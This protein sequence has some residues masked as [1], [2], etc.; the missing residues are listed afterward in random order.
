MKWIKTRNYFLKEAKI[1]DVILPKQAAQ[2][3]S[4]WGE[5][6]LDAEEIEPTE[7][8]IQGVWKL[9]KIGRAHV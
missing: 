5:K 6:W 2:V 9:S 3:K 7:K 8:I 4:Q 1:K